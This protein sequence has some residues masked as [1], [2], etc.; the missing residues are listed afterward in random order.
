MNRECS[1]NYEDR[2][3]FLIALMTRNY[4]EI[5]DVG[6]R[7]LKG[8]CCDTDVIRA[9]GILKQREECDSSSDTS[10]RSESDGET[11][12]DTTTD[13]DNDDTIT[14]NDNDDTT[15]DDDSDDSDLSDEQI[16]I[17]EQVESRERPEIVAT[18]APAKNSD[19]RNSMHRVIL[20]K[21][22]KRIL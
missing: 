19:F 5:R 20:I 14:D 10:I 4:A 9:L 21:L 1:A 13:D 8:G 22:D 18:S 15:I 6:N 3:E 7:L 11:S 2:L 17:Y 16:D 12:D